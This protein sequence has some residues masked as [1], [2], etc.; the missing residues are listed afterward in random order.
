MSVSHELGHF[1]A[2]DEVFIRGNVIRY[3]HLMKSD[4]DTEVLSETCRKEATKDKGKSH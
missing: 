4:V 1:K 3:I 2:C